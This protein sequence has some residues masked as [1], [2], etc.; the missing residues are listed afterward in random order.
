VAYD[1]LADANGELIIKPGEQPVFREEVNYGG[2][3]GVMYCTTKRLAWLGTKRGGAKISVG[4]SLTAVV[5][6]AVRTAA[7]KSRKHEVYIIL[8]IN[9]IQTLEV[10]QARLTV[11]AYENGKLTGYQ[12]KLMN[13][14]KARE[15]EQTLQRVIY[16]TG[17]N[18]IPQNENSQNTSMPRQSKAE[19]DFSIFSKLMDLDPA[20]AEIRISIGEFQEPFVE[21]KALYLEKLPLKET[22]ELLLRFEIGEFGIEEFV[23]KLDSI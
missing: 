23:Q 5:R 2:G 14:M 20:E 15:I 1:G 10:N 18:P 19:T 3:K 4:L 12:F 9:L 8:P 22:K 21:A 17:N 11:Y 16:S 7:S 13:E 6:T